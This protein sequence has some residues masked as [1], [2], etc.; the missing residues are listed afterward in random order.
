MVLMR[1]APGLCLW[2]LLLTAPVRASDTRPDA[3][4]ERM[5]NEVLDELRRLEGARGTQAE[6][7][8]LVAAKV[9]PVLDLER[10]TQTALG[11]NWR[12]ATGDQQL[13]LTAEFSTLLVRTYASVLTGY[14]DQTISYRRPRLTPEDTQATV[15]S[16]MVHSGG[17][18]L[19]IDYDMA[20]DAFGWRVYDIKIGGM[21]LVTSYR[22]RFADEVRENGVE[23]LVQS[24]AARNR[25]ADIGLRKT[26]D[27]VR[28]L[29]LRIYAYLQG[30]FYRTQ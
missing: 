23:G 27:S 1:L 14:R 24:L 12:L 5:T 7:L 17:R 6:V 4:L 15:K 11:R 28:E 3:M 8:K 29:T 13:A 10:M 22:D 30:A 18:R 2:L 20:K 21:S 9:V 19:P 26:V 16:E 25:P